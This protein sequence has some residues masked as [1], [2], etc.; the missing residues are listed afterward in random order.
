[1]SQQQFGGSWTDTK[2]ECLRRYLREYMKIMKSN[3][4][5]RFFTT[6][7]LD[8]FAG[9]GYIVRE[10]SKKETSISFFP[11][12]E[13]DENR[14]SLKK[15]SPCQ[16]LEIDPPFDRYI[17]VEKD[18]QKVFNL[19]RL[20]VEYPDKRIEIVQ[21]DAN[22]FILEWCDKTN[23][24]NNRAVVFLDPF[25]MQIDWPTIEKIAGTRSIDLWL[26]VP[27]GMGLI[28]MLKKNELPKSEWVAKITRFLGSDDWIK[29]FYKTT[30]TPTLFGEEEN[31]TRV[32]DYLKIGNYF[33]DR[34][35]SVFYAVAP[36]PLVLMNSKNNPIYLLVFAVGNEKAA[37]PALNIANYLINHL[38][39]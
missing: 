12:E 3:E 27:L 25:G 6:N 10:S 21:Q 36:K 4:R 7:Y 35:K 1:M 19:E 32:A 23:W 37:K 28:R 34:L 39:N 33:I 15:G 16:A 38:N 17:F 20:R 2:L 22:T 13:Q 14:E 30:I 24:I 5:A 29:I 11:D 18:Q 8:A 26:L 31:T 9:T